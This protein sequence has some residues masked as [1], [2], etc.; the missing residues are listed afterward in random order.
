MLTKTRQTNLRK[1]RL[2]DTELEVVVERQ[3]IICV[4]K[5]KKLST[6]ST[7]SIVNMKPIFQAVSSF[8]SYSFAKY[9]LSEN[10]RQKMWR[11]FEFDNFSLLRK[12]LSLP[13][14]KKQ[15]NHQNLVVS[16]HYKYI[17]FI[18]AHIYAL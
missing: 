13:P 1:S 7:V 6:V 14:F 15:K 5:F 8:M 3:R 11:P 16:S 18:Y 4:D 12:S 9:F 10:L 2:T 17:L